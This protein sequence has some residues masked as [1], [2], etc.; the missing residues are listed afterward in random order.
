MPSLNEAPLHSLPPTCLV[1]Y[2]CMVQDMFDPE[3]FLG[4]YEV[5]D[6]KAGQKVLRSGMFKD[7]ADCK[8]TW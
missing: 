2:R 3:Y 4:L 1:R 6:G 8:V 7:V 5:E